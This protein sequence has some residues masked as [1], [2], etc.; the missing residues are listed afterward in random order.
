[1]VDRSRIHEEIIAAP[2]RLRRCND[3]IEAGFLLSAA[4]IARIASTETSTSWTASATGWTICGVGYGITTMTTPSCSIHSADGGTGNS[5]Y[6]CSA[7]R[8]T[9]SGIAAGPSTRITLRGLA[10][11]NSN[12]PD[13]N[14]RKLSDT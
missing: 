14:P 5:R 10:T 13:R 1:V 8:L 4:D 3:W 7:R 2:A 11:E 9:A 12:K 6:G